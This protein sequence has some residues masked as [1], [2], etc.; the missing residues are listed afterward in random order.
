MSNNNEIMFREIKNI[1]NSNSKELN[2]AQIDNLVN[3]A[4]M[5]IESGDFAA[6]TSSANGQQFI[7][8]SINPFSTDE[9]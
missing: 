8:L 2:N 5:L 9:T 3:E 4:E 7:E 6:V 1:E